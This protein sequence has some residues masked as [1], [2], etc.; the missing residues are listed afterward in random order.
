MKTI[1]HVYAIK[2]ILSKGEVSDDYSYSNKLILHFLEVSRARL[3]E[4]KANKYHHISEQSYSSLCMDLEK[5][6][7]HNCCTGPD[8]KCLLKSVKEI[9]KTI[10][11]RFG[12]LTKVT[13]LAGN[14]IPMG[15]IT[16]DSLSQYSITAKNSTVWFIHDSK[17]YIK[18]NND[19]EKVVV[20]GL[21][22]NPEDSLEE[23][24]DSTT[25]NC[26]S[27]L[28]TEFPIDSDLIDAMYQLTLRYLTLPVQKDLMNDAREN[29]EGGQ[30]QG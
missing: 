26:P 12:N 2:N 22:L 19:L 17:L 5:G 11:T 3:I 30:P 9:P 13:D 16:T 27:Y 20:N 14:V 23:C 10:N 24:P 29:M 1:E 6:T 18:N 28:D 21:F 25:I 7:F 8:D 15:S 4:E